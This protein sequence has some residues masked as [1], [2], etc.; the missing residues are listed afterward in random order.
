VSL[1]FVSTIL[2]GLTV[3]LSAGQTDPLGI[4]LKLALPLFALGVA[5]GAIVTPNQALTLMDVDPSIGGSAG[6]VLQTAQRAGSATGQT[7][8]GTLFFASVAGVAASQA[9]GQPASDPTTFA[10][11][12]MVGILGSLVFSG[13]ALVLGLVD[14]RRHRRRS[15]ITADAT[16]PLAE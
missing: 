12:L 9:V 2:I 14:L 4:I 1:F 8:L 7:V 5:G 3:D 11:A 10:H 16:P 13:S 15:T 6:G